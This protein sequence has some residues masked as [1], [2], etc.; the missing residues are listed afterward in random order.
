[1]HLRLDRITE[2]HELNIPVKP[3]SKVSPYT[4]RFDVADYT[5][6]LFNMF[7]GEA[8][9]I[10]LSFSKNV[11]DEMLEKFGENVPIKQS[12][13]GNYLLHAE[14]EM[15]EGLVNWILQY[16]CDVKV[17][18]PKSLANAVKEKLSKILEMYE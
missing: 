5:N 4:D 11:L 3:F 13:D 7:S 14:V 1:M 2:L 9:N 10:V 18:K 8:E 15:S 6:R 16:G 12:E 17:I